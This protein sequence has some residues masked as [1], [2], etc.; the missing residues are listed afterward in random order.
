MLD[1]FHLPFPTAD[2]Q[3]FNIPCTVTN[4]QWKTWIKP[5]GKS[6]MQIIC[7]GG[8]GG[9]GGGFTG[10]ATSARGGGGSG[11]SS[12]VTRITM[13]LSFVPDIL[14]VQTGAGGQGVGSGGG[15]AGAGILSYVSIHPNITAS[16][17]I[18]ISGAAGAGGGGTGTAARS[19]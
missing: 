5:R 17:N 2:I 8:G 14:F 1:T 12:A 7:I 9:G 4:T 3:I 16:N 10:I 18:V 13:P 6:M 15:T 11:G 19:E